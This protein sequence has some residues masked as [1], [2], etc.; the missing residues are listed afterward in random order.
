MFNDAYR[1]PSGEAF[2]VFHTYW[3]IIGRSI[4][5]R[6]INCHIYDLSYLLN[7]A[8]LFCLSIF[9]RIPVLRGCF[10]SRFYL[11]FHRNIVTSKTSIFF[12]RLF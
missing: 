2:N 12:K 3:S 7:V 4:I 1:L 9:C 8:S 11:P 5:R 10:F 6:S